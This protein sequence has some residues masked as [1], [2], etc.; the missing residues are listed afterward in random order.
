MEDIFVL[1]DK[2]VN[3]IKTRG[4]SLPLQI[5]KEIQKNSIITSAFLSELASEKS[6]RISNLKVGSSPLYFFPGQ[7]TKLEDF[8]IH[9]PAKEREAFQLL[10]EKGILKDKNLEPAIRVA[11]RSI[12]DFAFPLVLLQNTERIIF[13]RYLSM[14]EDE[15]KKRI[16]EI[17]TK[18]IPAIPITK[19]IIQETAQQPQTREPKK[20]IEITAPKKI[21]EARKKPIEKIEKEK[22]EE[23]L[24][25]KPLITL[26]SK[27][28][29]EKEKEKSDFV[30]RIINFL[31]KE[32]IELL[33]EKESKKREFISIIRINTDLGKNN[34]LCI[35]KD[36]KKISENDLRIAFQK[37]QS[38]KLPCLILSAG[39]LDKKAKICI[40]EYQNLIKIMKIQ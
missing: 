36:K 18:S 3:L 37:S 33:E 4:P 12:K 23:K 20:I 17:V 27:I 22:P 38:W 19:E 31:E 5:A 2:I 34:M 6:I 35:A 14:A 29:P 16:E 25:E 9:L 15:A 30:K 40:E 24:I 13:W 1:K 28:K 21:R 32:N 39:E 10:K 7:E 26:K 11:L 8:S